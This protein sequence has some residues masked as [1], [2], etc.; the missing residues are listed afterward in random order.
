MPGTM[1]SITLTCSDGHRGRDLFIGYVFAIH[2]VYIYTTG[3]KVVYRSDTIV[4]LVR[5]CCYRH[6]GS[7]CYLI[8]LGHVSSSNNTGF[9][10]QCFE[11]REQFRRSVFV[12]WPPTEMTS[13]PQVATKISQTY[14]FFLGHF[15]FFCSHNSA[16]PTKMTYYGN[17]FIS[18]I[19]YR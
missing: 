7:C 17:L 14:N 6:H 13:F 9:V 11:R 18:V 12:L 4:V 16:L 10:Q 8:H 19:L 5:G 2:S 15:R 3:G 1:C